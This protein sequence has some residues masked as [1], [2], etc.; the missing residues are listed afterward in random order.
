MLK[1]NKNI[2][3]DYWELPK[4]R[5][6][7]FNPVVESFARPKAE[8][9]R[10][11]MLD[12][13][14]YTK[15]LDIGSGNG[16]FTWILNGWGE[17]IAFDFSKQM[18]KTNPVGQKIQGDAAI[19]PFKD[20]SFDVVFCSNLLHHVEEPL[21]VVK[22][23]AR[24]SSQFVALSEPNSL[25]PLMFLFGLLKQEERGS[26]KFN[27]AYLTQLI[28]DAGMESIASVSQGTIVPNMTPEI[29]LPILRLIDGEFPFGFFSIA[30]GKKMHNT[31]YNA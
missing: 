24:V 23:M 31:T 3:K 8:F 19:L 1:V 28:N 27:K 29:M 16:Y 18:L 26:L 5:R 13:I 2:Q 15:V 17:V 12:N 22:E 10:K 9:I 14:I 21:K 20:N 25:N 30:I 11:Y 7:P 4:K 6:S